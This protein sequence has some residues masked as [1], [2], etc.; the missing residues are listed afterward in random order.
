[1]PGNRDRPRNV[2]GNSAVELNDMSDKGIQLAR[3]V[4]AETNRR[5]ATDHDHEQ[6]WYASPLLIIAAIVFATWLLGLI[7]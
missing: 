4:I 3:D 1:M 2:L 7:P 6:R 5:R